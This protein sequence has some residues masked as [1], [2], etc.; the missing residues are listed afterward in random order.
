[1]SSNAVNKLGGEVEN[2]GRSHNY[3][4]NHGRKAIGG[5]LYDLARSEHVV[6]SFQIWTA[7][8]EHES[9]YGHQ[10][11]GYPLHLRPASVKGC[12]PVRLHGE[13]YPTP[14]QPNHQTFP[15]RAEQGSF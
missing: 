10:I 4:G 2:I 11:S 1:M 3:R 12:V 8:D 13:R 14:W 5:A 15:G 7:C 9:L 6:F